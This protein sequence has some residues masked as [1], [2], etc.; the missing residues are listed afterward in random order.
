MTSHAVPQPGKPTPPRWR[1]RLVRVV[2][3][4]AV[5]YIMWCGAL[6]FMQDRML[7]L[8]GLAGPPLTDAQI[9]IAAERLWVTLGDGS[10]VEAWL[11]VAP[12]RTAERPGPAV[13]FAHG[14]A[15]LIDHQDAIVEQYMN[16]AVSILVAEF[17]GYGRSTGR[18]SQASI[19]EALEGFRA[20]LIARPEVDAGKLV[21]HGRSLGT[22]AVAQ[23]AKAY[24]PAGMVLESPFTS[25]AAFAARYAAP[26]FIVRNP[27]R[28][29][30]VLKSL[31]VPVVILHSK[32][33]EIVPV[34]HSRTLA[35]LAPNATLV[36]VEGSHNDWVGDDPR[37]WAAVDAML[38]AIERR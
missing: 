17:P 37:S 5:F 15:E 23:L 36:E 8:P 33:D 32:G 35:R 34:E 11:F 1:R 21:Y 30:E 18:P 31:D 2:R 24:P 22:G 27:F 29:D 19:G 9:P 28:T 3:F 12:G 7:F 38:E 13:I 16:R 14:N 26:A 25:V 4:V 20:L 6:Y 10:R